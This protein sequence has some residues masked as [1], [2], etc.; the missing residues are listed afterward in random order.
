VTALLML[1]TLEK[2]ICSCLHITLKTIWPVNKIRC[3]T[4]TKSERNISE[5]ISQTWTLQ[6]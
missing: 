2:G 4:L 5:L 6:I 1:K 3:N